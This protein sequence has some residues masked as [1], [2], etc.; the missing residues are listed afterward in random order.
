MRVAHNWI[1]VESPVTLKIWERGIEMQNVC[2]FVLMAL[3]SLSI[4]ISEASTD[5]PPVLIAPGEGRRESVA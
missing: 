5:V 2:S 4:Q 3:F 1:S